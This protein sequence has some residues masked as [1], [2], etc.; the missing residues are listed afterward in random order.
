MKTLAAQRGRSAC[1]G[2]GPTSG[3]KPSPGF[4]KCKKIIELFLLNFFFC[5]CAGKLSRKNKKLSEQTDKKPLAVNLQSLRM[6]I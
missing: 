5:F 6:P 2:C 1:R 4:L 3:W